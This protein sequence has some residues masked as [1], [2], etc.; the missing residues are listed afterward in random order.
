MSMI[1]RQSATFLACLVAVAAIYTPGAYGIGAPGAIHGGS[2]VELS[3]GL[4]L[5]LVLV[6]LWRRVGCRERIEG[7]RGHS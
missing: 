7:C 6:M 5:L 1:L 3:L 4:G 2:L